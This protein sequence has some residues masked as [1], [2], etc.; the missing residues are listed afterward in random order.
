MMKSNDKKSVFDTDKKNS[1]DGF[2]LIVPKKKPV[3]ITNPKI[4]NSSVPVSMFA[5][6]EIESDQDDDDDDDENG[7]N[8]KSI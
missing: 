3:I 2:K 1:N 6:L 7:R 4:T 5:G 8:W